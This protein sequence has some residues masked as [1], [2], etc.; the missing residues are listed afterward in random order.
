MKRVSITSAVSGCLKSRNGRSSQKINGAESPMFQ[1]DELDGEIKLQVILGF[2]DVPFIESQIKESMDTT[3]TE[4]KQA[5][6]KRAEDHVAKLLDQKKRAVKLA[7]QFDTDA[8]VAEGLKALIQD[9]DTAETKVKKLDKELKLT[10]T[11]ADAKAMALMLRD[12]FSTFALMDMPTQKALLQKHI[13][14]IDVKRDQDAGTMVTFRV[15]VGLPEFLDQM[16]EYTP[17]PTTPTIPPD[18]SGTFAVDSTT[19]PDI[20]DRAVPFPSKKGS[21]MT[22]TPLSSS[23]TR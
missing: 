9:I 11:D 15:R 19:L 12:Q 6:L 23:T 7:M 14:R 5:A 8:D 22:R 20:G 16:T 3:R 18:R 17:E 4:E 13:E 2:T 21:K 10:V 1:R